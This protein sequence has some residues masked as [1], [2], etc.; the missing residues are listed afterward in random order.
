MQQVGFPVGRL[1]LGHRAL[2]ALS[3]HEPAPTLPARA[4]R[5]WQAARYRQCGDGSEAA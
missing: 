5:C 4:Q 2:V 1:L 3:Q